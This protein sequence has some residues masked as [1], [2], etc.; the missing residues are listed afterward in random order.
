MRNNPP[1]IDL[2]QLLEVQPTASKSEIKR[3][4]VGQIQRWHPDKAAPGFEDDATA[5]IKQLNEAREW[6]TDDEKKRHYN[7]YFQRH[8]GDF[9]ASAVDQFKA[10]IGRHLDDTS[11]ASLDA[12]FERPIEKEI[13]ISIFDSSL[14]DKYKLNT[15]IDEYIIK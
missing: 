3:A 13:I 2:Y 1:N 4:Y 14:F 5:V 6:L 9:E 15:F 7:A 12:Y 10:R 11:R 8:R